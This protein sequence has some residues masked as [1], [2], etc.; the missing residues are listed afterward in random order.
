MLLSEDEIKPA[1][2]QLTNWKLANNCITKT[3]IFIT[4]LAVLKF[5]NEVATVAELMQHHPE[6]CNVYNKLEVKLTTHDAGGVT[7]KDI[8][9]AKKMDEIARSNSFFN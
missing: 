8:E 2:L 7:Q 5:M 1:L 9:L 4:F 3:Y 6:W